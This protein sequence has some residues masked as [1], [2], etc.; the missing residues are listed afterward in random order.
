[1][2]SPGIGD[3]GFQGLEH[4]GLSW[5]FVQVRSGLELLNLRLD[6]GSNL[7]EFP[8]RNR[9]ANPRTP[10]NL[11]L[12]QALLR[13]IALP[14]RPTKYGV[15]NQRLERIPLRGSRLRLGRSSSSLPGCCRHVSYKVSDRRQ[16]IRACHWRHNHIHRFHSSNSPLR[17]SSLAHE[18]PLAVRIH[19]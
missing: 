10:N 9:G 5:G 1:M 15:A 8:S 17:L 16:T 3:R 18:A 19:A 6:V 4:E 7:D 11:H 2:A 13:R 14:R 12:V